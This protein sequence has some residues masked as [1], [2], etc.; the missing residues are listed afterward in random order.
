MKHKKGLH[1][2]A[3]LLGAGALL[4]T[5]IAQAVGNGHFEFG[6]WEICPTRKIT[7]ARKFQH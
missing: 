3:T 1:M 2:F 4:T 5:S 7:T 6:I